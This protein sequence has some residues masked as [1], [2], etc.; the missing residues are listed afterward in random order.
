[1]N[2]RRSFFKTLIGATV[3]VVAATI[4]DEDFITLPIEEALPKR[5]IPLVRRAWPNIIQSEIV[6]IQPMD[7]PTGQVFYM[8]YEQNKTKQNTSEL[9]DERINTI[10]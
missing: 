5:L 10:I 3:S 1:M 2:S 4:I 8:K 7:G 6:G 9:P